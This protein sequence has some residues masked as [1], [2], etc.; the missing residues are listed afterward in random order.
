MNAKFFV[1]F[2]TAKILKEKGYPQDFAHNDALYTLPNGKFYWTLDV[3][4][5]R[6]CSEG[7]PIL[8]PTY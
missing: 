2:E 6:R 5:A 4:I 3:D 1:P 8:T 7:E